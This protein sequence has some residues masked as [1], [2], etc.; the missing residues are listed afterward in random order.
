M[1]YTGPLATEDQIAAER[2]A[3]Q[4]FSGPEIAGLRPRLRAI[5]AADPAAKIPAGFAQIDHVLDLW[6]MSMIM[7]HL[8]S[9]TDTPKI[10]WHVENTPHTWFGHEFPGMGAAGD[11]PD[12][13]YRGAFLDG[14]STYAITGK[15]GANRPAQLSLELFRGAPGQT[16][17]T[18]QTSSTPDLGNQ[19][20]LIS[21]D[22]MAIAPDGS[23]TVTIG[24]DAD[25]TD[26][27]HLATAPGPLQLAIRDVLSD[28][29]QE[30]TTLTITR[31]GGPAAAAPLTKAQLL[32]NILRDLPGFLQFW[33][34][35]KT[36][37]LGGIADNAIAG[38]SPRAGGWG[39]LL[40]GRYNLGDDMAIVL[41]VDDVGASYIGC[42]GLSPWLM[43]SDDA[44]VGTLCLNGAQVARNP[45]G[46][47][48]YVLSRSD[49]G[50]ANWIDTNGMREG[51][52]II[53]WQGVPA[54][55]DPRRMLSEFRLIALADM[56]AAIPDTVPRIDAAGRAAQVAARAA[57]FDRRLG[58]PV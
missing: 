33:S 58:T 3:L 34:S 24:P 40:G 37:W 11:N 25:A 45:D 18:Q 12:H 21:S 2:L 20:S 50:L 39:Y 16:V 47:I 13:I 17:M 6:T 22:G 1:R 9:D 48:T 14:A 53:R 15:M 31:T 35:F 52:F 5:L 46:T 54:G 10:L 23:F 44:R 51:M 8:G 27:N 56:P 29:G 41:T 19:V 38:P 57:E 36:N 42:Q 49:P 55:A 4:F 28:W 43:M 26:P 32:A 30:P 7:W